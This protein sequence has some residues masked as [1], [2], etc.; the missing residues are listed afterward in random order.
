MVDKIT[1]YLGE[2]G[3]KFYL[4]KPEREKKKEIEK[5]P[6][7]LRE[8]RL[9]DFWADIEKA[10]G[11]DFDAKAKSVVN[12]ANVGLAEIWS[13]D[14]FKEALKKKILTLPLGE[15]E[16]LL[17]LI[18]KYAEDELYSRQ[19]NS[20]NHR[21]DGINQAIL[22]LEKSFPKP[23]DIG[24]LNGPDYPKERVGFADNRPYDLWLTQGLGEKRPVFFEPYDR[25][26]E[27]LSEFYEK[28][29]LPAWE[30]ERTS[31]QVTSPPPVEKVASVP[32][33]SLPFNEIMEHFPDLLRET[34]DE[35]PHT[36]IYNRKS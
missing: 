13:E 7:P 31:Q 1:N 6:K 22:A 9:D 11:V 8:K 23:F 2:I 20:W 17:P 12:S 35:E 34:K 30:A 18:Q 16:E 5:M 10:L 24:M 3:A 28:V 27:K 25:W 15:R 14:L 33:S 29:Y 26:A 32:R 4:V 36:K 21:L 19:L